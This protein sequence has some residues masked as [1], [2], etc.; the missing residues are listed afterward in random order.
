[1]YFKTLNN[2]KVKNKKVL[3]RADLN[4][5]LKDGKV[6]NDYRMR[7]ILP[8][9]DYLINAGAKVILAS[10]LGRPIG[11]EKKLSMAVIEP[12][13]AKVLKRKVVFAADCIGSDVKKIIRE[14][15]QTQV[16]LLENLR[17]Y[18]E[19]EMNDADF[20]EELASIAD[21][22]VN[23]AFAVCHRR[24]ASVVGITEYLPSAAG[25]LLAKE[26][27]VLTKSIENPE[28]PLVVIMGGVKAETKIRI[29]KRMLKKA[30]KI[31]LGG[32]LAIIALKAK[33]IDIGASEICGIEIGNSFNVNSPKIVLPRDVVAARSEDGKNTAQER[34]INKINFDEKI[35]DIGAETAE[36]FI[37]IVKQAKTIIWN[38]PMGL[39]EDDRFSN[40]TKRL[41]RAVAASGAYT[42]VGG[43]D[44]I[45]ALQK[46]S[47]LDRIKHISTGG[48]AMLAFIEGE[49]MPGI[50]ALS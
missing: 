16:I 20:S 39:F 5:K 7:M 31:I 11:R 35:F 18:P 25:F 24:H 4:V 27:N 36:E 34:E 26:I 19:E 28:R 22:Y 38:G 6:E 47:F 23:E 40:G 9:V 49:E 15:P 42:V 8:T 1:M 21:I 2:L 44:T 33:G 46:F 37:G 32:I 43:G 41:A 30:D 14:T 50:D 17:F 29:V 12:A 48:G 13:L 10:H 3:V 45:A